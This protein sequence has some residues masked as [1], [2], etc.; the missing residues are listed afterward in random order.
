SADHRC[1]CARLG[2]QADAAQ[3]VTGGQRA[4]RKSPARTAHDVEHG[5]FR[6]AGLPEGGSSEMIDAQLIDRKA[7]ARQPVDEVALAVLADMVV[8]SV[9]LP[10]QRGCVD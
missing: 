6:D 2:A 3:P 1:P 8:K 4:A 7:R 9:I 5:L 10:A